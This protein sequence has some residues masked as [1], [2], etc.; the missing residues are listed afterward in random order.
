MLVH[1]AASGVKS[2]YENDIYDLNIFQSLKLFKNA[3]SNK[4]KNWLLISTSSEYGLKKKKNIFQY[5]NKQN[6]RN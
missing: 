4:C 6:S 3:V 2:D 1:F 5:Q